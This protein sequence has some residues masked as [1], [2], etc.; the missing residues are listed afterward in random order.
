MSLPPLSSTQV[1]CPP[2]SSSFGLAEVEAVSSAASASVG[3]ELSPGA[4][5]H[6]WERPRSSYYHR[7][8]QR[9]RQLDFSLSRRSNFRGEHRS[10]PQSVRLAQ[11]PDGRSENLAVCYGHGPYL[12][13]GAVDQ[14]GGLFFV[15][16]LPRSHR[17]NSSACNNVQRCALR[18]PIIFPIA[19]FEAA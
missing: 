12:W 4:V 11:K 10:P 3:C 2:S 15:K 13:V 19:T 6:E 7:Q 14:S 8:S 18:V 1:S 16:R 5:L 17:H 9:A